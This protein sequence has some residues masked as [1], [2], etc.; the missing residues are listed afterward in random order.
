MCKYP[1]ILVHGIANKQTRLLNAFGQIGTMLE[2]DGNRV[3][4]AET[5][6]FGSIESNAEQLKRFILAVLKKENAEKVNVIAHS[7]GGLDTKYMITDLG[8]ESAVA[9]LTTLCTPHQG[10]IIASKIWDLPEEFHGLYGL[11]GR[12]ELDTSG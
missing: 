8:M 9:S 10:S 6:A 7:K 4:V 11:W 1:I 5:D 2:K 12:K 3:Y